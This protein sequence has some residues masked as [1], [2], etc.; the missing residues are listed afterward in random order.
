MSAGDTPKWHRYLRFWRTNVAADVDDELAFHVDARTQELREA[1]MDTV[2]ARAQALAEFGDVERTRVTLRAMDKQHLTHEHRA[3]VAADLLRDV[4]VALRGLRRSPALVAVVT[5]TFAL[6][7]GVTTA[8]YSLV[9]AFLFRPLPGAYGGE[10]VALGRTDADIPLPHVLTYPDFRDFRADTATFASLMA[11]TSRVATLDNG[12]G[13]DRLW[14][15]EGTANYFSTLGLRPMLGRTFLPGEDDGVLA[16]PNLVLT[17]KAWQSHFG[18]D[19]SVIGRVVRINDHPMTIIGV[20]PPD[21]HGVLPLVDIDGVVCLNQ[22]WPASPQLLE[23]R[24]SFSM[25]VVGRLRAGV[26]RD[27]A[28][29]AVELEAQRLERAYPTTNK[30]VGV[31]LVD[32]RYSRPSISVSRVT[33]ALAAIFMTLVFLVLAVACANVASLLLSRV[34]GRGREL[35]IR[36]AIGASQWR[37]VRQVMVECAL[38]ALLGGVGAVAVAAL[39]I[40]A[41]ASI[42]IATDLPIRW[43]VELDAR[44]L[45]FTAV[46]T[47]LAAVATGL[48]PGLAA[49]RRNL[50]A[51]LRS[52]AG[53]AGVRAQ[54]RLRSVLVAG[55]IAVSAVVLV[56]AGLFVRSSSTVSRMPLGF[57]TDH[58]LLVSTALP[59][60]RYDSTRGRALYRELS[61][62]VA[63]L[64]GVRSVGLTR[65]LPFGF[66]RDNLSV[67]PIASAVQAPANGF[68]YFTDVVGA[69]YFDALGIP[70]LDGRDFSDRD[71]ARAP[72]VAI[73]NDAFARAFWPG[74]PAVGKQFHVDGGSGPVLEIVGVVRGMQ[75]LLPGETPKPYVFLPLEQTYR[76]E[77]TLLVQSSGSP[78]SLAPAI[79]S[80][81]ASLDASLPIFD[82]RTMDE[83]LRNG[84]AFLFTRIGAAF[85]SVFG[86]LALVLA[87]IGVYGV[88][89]YA[90]AQRTREIGV[91]V[92]LGA[93]LPGILG[94]VVRH[95]LRLAWSGVAVGIVVSFAVTGV[96]A[97]ILYGVKPHD[98]LVLGGVAALLT[99]IAVVASF[100]PA[101]RATRIDPI[102]ALRA[103]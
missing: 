3:D 47:L 18:G 65:F 90:V 84:Q 80:T 91:R 4:R 93:T 53:N 42:H 11:F 82:V 66:E 81:V 67:V 43:G 9:D 10:L 73:V 25:N 74:Q 77:M 2:S 101:R 46:V 79:R 49:R 15:D 87:M 98:P 61:H 6:G 24:R 26:S 57:R 19:S 12:R 60:Q 78:L 102:T 72:R 86:L 59:T 7:I 56:C 83:H 27:R 38:L 54:Q 35:A 50:S 76:D 89:S 32:E 85:A 70:L 33:P 16:H 100:A 14:I 103:E 34:V 62:R 97:S 37:I 30:N 17:Y 64:P 71:D 95:G 8:I 55:Q 41:I 13:A 92:A 21:F 51:L 52:S 94:L 96:L 39:A 68:S 23:D 29:R 1:G 99:A 44:V 88:V 63:A 40:R 45:G 69:K 28:R 58:V 5:L 48:V 20:T 75:D 36:A 31:V 22:L